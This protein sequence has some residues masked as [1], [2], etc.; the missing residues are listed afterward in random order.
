MPRSSDTLRR[1]HAAAVQNG[2][3]DGGVHASDSAKLPVIWLLALVT[4]VFS[5]QLAFS[6][7][8]QALE[9]GIAE[10]VVLVPFPL[11]AL[12][13]LAWA[14]L[15]TLRWRRFGRAELELESLPVSAGGEFRAMLHLGCT[16]PMGT[17]FT[18]RLSCRRRSRS[19]E[20]SADTIFWESTQRADPWTVGVGPLGARVPVFFTIPA[21]ATLPS[22]DPPTTRTP[23]VW[24]LQAEA[25]LAGA[26]LSATFEV[27]LFET[28][29]RAEEPSGAWA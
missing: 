29:L 26:D 14:V 5:V 18:L 24:R 4:T 20:R 3:V 9:E 27:P 21:E 13:L 11:A 10:V 19:H 2:R 16:V 1:H 25:K 23:V 7:L 15:T 6:K 22:P 12:G 28:S 8:P 17:G